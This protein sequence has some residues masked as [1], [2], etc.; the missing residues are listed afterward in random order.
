MQ[1]FSGWTSSHPMTSAQL[2]LFLW[3]LSIVK[4]KEKQNQNFLLF[5][6][7][8][9]ETA[10]CQPFLHVQCREEE[11]YWLY[12]YVYLQIYAIYVQINNC[13]GNMEI[14]IPIKQLPHLNALLKGQFIKKMKILFQT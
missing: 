12:V 1:K 14:I 7:T 9:D 8:D 2:K 6:R 5:G 10:K 4:P 3:S 11:L 13:I